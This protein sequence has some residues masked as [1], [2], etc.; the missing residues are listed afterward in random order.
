MVLV[1]LAVGGA[2]DLAI[3]R[4][5]YRQ[6]RRRKSLL[7]SRDGHC[8]EFFG[9]TRGGSRSA[10]NYA[11]RDLLAD[12]DYCFVYIVYSGVRG[13]SSFSL[14]FIFC[15]SHRLWKKMALER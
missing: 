10:G 9:H 3:N 6:Y 14:S 7:E 8:F 15:R 11:G 12:L 5:V 1:V 13:R 2:D 4:W